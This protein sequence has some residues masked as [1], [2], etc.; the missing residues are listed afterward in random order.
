MPTAVLPDRISIAPGEHP[1]RPRHRDDHFQHRR[2]VAA[3]TNYDLRAT[4]LNQAGTSTT[5]SALVSRGNMPDQRG[6][7]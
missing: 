4:A 6:R 5:P 2:R 7:P 1:A 3:S